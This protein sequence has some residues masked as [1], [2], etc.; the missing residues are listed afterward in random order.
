MTK[1]ISVT[2]LRD[3]ADRQV[4]LIDVRSASEFAAG[5][6]PQAV[7]VPMD[8]IEGRLEDLDTSKPLILICQAGKR[9]RMT[10]GLLEPCG[11]DVAI[12]EGGTNEWVEAGLPLVRSVR[13]RWSLERQVRMGAGLLT[14]AGA[15]LSL[16]VDVRWAFL[17]A[18]VGMGLTFA[19]LTDLC[20]MA[21]VLQ[22]MPWNVR[23][24]CT[25]SGP[26]SDLCN[27]GQ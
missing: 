5:H 22:K 19:G 20:P 6:V 24:H 3:S 4:Q 2:E 25:L 23:S 14:L 11:R 16:V 10:A 18:F 21:I 8:E 13:S 9:A 27:G 7:N 15:A 12:L 26:S 1:S 17:A